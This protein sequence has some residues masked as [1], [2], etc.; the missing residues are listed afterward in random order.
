MSRGCDVP[1][2]TVRSKGSGPAGLS[3][4]PGPSR[5]TTD[6]P[7]SPTDRRIQAALGLDRKIEIP[8][9]IA[10]GYALTAGR[11]NGQREEP[12]VR[13]QEIPAVNPNRGIKAA[14]GRCAMV[15]A[16][17]DQQGHPQ[18]QPILRR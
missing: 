5:R 10:L 14:D 15:V 3:S 11:P 9:P 6:S 1:S 13:E 8:V 16:I 18:G 2:P 7:L 4:C 17:V 12:R